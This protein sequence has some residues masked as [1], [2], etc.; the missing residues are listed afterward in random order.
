[1]L[2]LCGC[3]GISNFAGSDGYERTKVEAKFSSPWFW[4]ICGAKA[5]CGKE[6]FLLK[7]LWLFCGYKVTGPPAAKSGSAGC[8]TALYSIEIIN[9]VFVF[10][11]INELPS[12]GCLRSCNDVV[13]GNVYIKLI[14]AFEISP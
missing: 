7:A 12:V 9:V 3:R 8:K 4:L 13:I 6:A 1:M 10:I 2:D 14:F 11:C 5:L